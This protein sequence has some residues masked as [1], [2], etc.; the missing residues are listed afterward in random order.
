MT[1]LT[2]LTRDQIFR[3]FLLFDID[4]SHCIDFNKFYLLSCIL[5][6]VKDGIE[7]SFIREH[8]R[9][10]FTLLDH[11][12]SGVVLMSEFSSIAFL[13]NLPQIT[14][15]EVMSDLT[16]TRH[17]ELDIDQFQLAIMAIIA[18]VLKSRELTVWQKIWHYLK[19]IL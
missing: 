17:S 7:K 4:K 19:V 3:L 6:A 18:K 15:A 12:Q 9:T 5:I 13:F 2:N 10:I 11:S 1:I 16:L 14:I 8:S